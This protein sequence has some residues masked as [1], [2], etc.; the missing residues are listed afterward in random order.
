MINRKEIQIGETFETEGIQ[1]KCE[2][3]K[4]RGCSYCFI[5]TKTGLNCTKCLSD[6]RKDN[7]D[8]IFV[9]VK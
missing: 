3:A 1:V 8:V 2:A 9:E 6:E 4:G 7:T 5:S